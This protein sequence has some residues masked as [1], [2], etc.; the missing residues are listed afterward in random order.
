MVDLLNHLPPGAKVLD[1]GASAGSFLTSRRDLCIVRLDLR[2]PPVRGAGHYVSADAARV[3]FAPRTFD[4]V[5]SN[6]S[7]E[8][9]S[10]LEAAVREVGRVIKPDGI[11]Y[12]AVPDAG[13]FTDHVYRW[14][15]NGGGHVNAFRSP[16]EV[17]TLVERL[18]GLR[19][20]A[21]QTLFSSLS[22]LNARNL[23]GPPSKRMALFAFGNERFLMVFTWMLRLSDR[24]LGTGLSRYGWSFYFGEVTRPES[25]EQWINVCVRCGS[26]H[27]GKMLR[28]AGVVRRA[29]FVRVY[30][31]PVCGA[32]NIWTPEPGL[33]CQ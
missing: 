10:N 11:F 9:F 27:A 18:T 30:Q 15:A 28:A 23:P 6:H 12:V 1:L 25:A 17:V 3:P 19:H 14:L 8:H 7:L 32:V 16:A 2:I 29:G 4:L 20:R 22:F 13:T 26:G 33:G 24:W 21:T 5:V 31:C